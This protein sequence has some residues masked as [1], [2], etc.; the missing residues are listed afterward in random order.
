MS[1]ESPD[2]EGKVLFDRGNPNR[3]CVYS[4]G[5]AGEGIHPDFLRFFQGTEENLAALARNDTAILSQEGANERYLKAFED[6]IRELA[7]KYP[8]VNL[9]GNSFGTYLSLL[10]ASKTKLK[11]N[12][13]LGISSLV[14]PF[15]LFE[16]QM[17]SSIPGL[18]T[19]PRDELITIPL[20]EGKDI[21]ICAGN[22]CDWEV[23]RLA[24]QKIQRRALLI[25][26][27]LDEFEIPESLKILAAQNDSV[28]FSIIPGMKHRNWH[29][30][31]EVISK[32]Q[33]F[34]FSNS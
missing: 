33:E 26:G 5:L 18:K 7:A 23:A 24:Q 34:L 32:A 12:K 25:L 19:K 17:S 8:E 10:F 11:V 15:G 16:R 31:R 30:F 20:L 29:E 3:I 14:D 6:F 2:F 27:E 28:G 1:E 13:V 22:I 9:I 21:D 4:H